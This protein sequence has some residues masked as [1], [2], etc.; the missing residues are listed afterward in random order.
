LHKKLSL[1]SQETSTG[2]ATCYDL[3]ENFSLINNGYVISAQT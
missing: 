2:D 1:P 3:G